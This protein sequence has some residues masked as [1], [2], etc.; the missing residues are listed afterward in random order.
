MSETQNKVADL[1][2]SQTRALKTFRKNQEAMVSDVEKR[3]DKLEGKREFAVTDV[4][5]YSE[6]FDSCANMVEAS[7]HPKLAAAAL[8][9]VA[10]SINLATMG[11]EALAS[12]LRVAA[13]LLP[14]EAAK[15]RGKLT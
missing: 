6:I 12:S 11:A 15:A 2:K 5:G 7:Q 8:L 1:I 3:V 14:A 4:R 9:N 10:L 13:D